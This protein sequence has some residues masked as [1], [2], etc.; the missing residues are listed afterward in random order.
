M[1]KQQKKGKSGNRKH[2]R[3]MLKCAQYSAGKRR[4]RNKLKRIRQSNGFDA[5]KAYA[6]G[7]G[8]KVLV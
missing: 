7:H 8:L 6:I 1:P 5:A 2:G 4:E 3:D